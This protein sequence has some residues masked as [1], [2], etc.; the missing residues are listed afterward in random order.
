MSRYILAHDFQHKPIRRDEIVKAGACFAP[1]TLRAAL[2]APICSRSGTRLDARGAF[3]ARA[4]LRSAA[5]RG[6]RP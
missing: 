4:R 3:P 5:Q 2:V 6:R 1:L